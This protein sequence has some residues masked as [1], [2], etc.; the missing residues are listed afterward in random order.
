MKKLL[1]GAIGA[2]MITTAAQAEDKVVEM[3]FSH[4]LPTQHP[5][6]S[7][8]FRVWADSIAEDSNGTRNN[9]V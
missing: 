6:H 5:L 3:T 7:E 8:G 9:F 1:L 4:D 2:L